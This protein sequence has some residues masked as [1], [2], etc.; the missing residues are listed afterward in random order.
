MFDKLNKVEAEVGALT[1][2]A[3]RNCAHSGVMYEG[4]DG[5]DAMA[6]ATLQRGRF[7]K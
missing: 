4:G 3:S 6:A 2:S 7:E 5:Y 1:M